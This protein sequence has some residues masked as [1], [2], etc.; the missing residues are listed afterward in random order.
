M[1]NISANKRDIV[2][3]TVE[4]R[5]P[6]PS[7]FVTQ[8]Q[9]FVSSNRPDGYTVEVQCEVTGPAP[10]KPRL[11]LF[12]V[13]VATMSAVVVWIHCFTIG[14]PRGYAVDNPFPCLTSDKAEN[15]CPHC[16]C[17]PCVV[18]LP[19]DFLRGSGCAHLRNTEKQF[20]L[21]RKFRGLLQD[22]KI[23]EHP[24]YLERKVSRLPLTDDREIM[25]QC[26]VQVGNAQQVL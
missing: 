25:P 13:V 19:P 4:S 12:S 5:D 6:A 22:L 8:L 18:S 11:G 17:E 1:Y 23:W 9:D 26:I 15:G 16:L 24:V 2:Q 20:T 14:V 3:I 7:T 10:K 21:Y